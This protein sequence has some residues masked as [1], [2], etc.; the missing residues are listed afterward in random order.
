MAALLTG[1]PVLSLLTEVWAR[2]V[3]P[4][5][6]FR[7]APDARPMVFVTLSADIFISV[8]PLVILVGI[9]AS[10]SNVS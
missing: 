4:D 9:L 1:T 5:V 2:A 10:V 6:V 8:E 3:A 7:T